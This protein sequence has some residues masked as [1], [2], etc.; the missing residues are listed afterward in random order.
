[1]F[2]SDFTLHFQSGGKTMKRVLS[3][4]LALCLGASLFAAPAYASGEASAEGG[5]VGAAISV[6]DGV[7]SLDEDYCA[8]HGLELSYDSL[9]NEG[10]TGLTLDT[11]DM[12][13]SAVSVTGD[14]SVFTIDQADIHLGVNE[15]TAYVSSS[16]TAGSGAL[17]S[18]GTLF[19]NDSSIVVDGGANGAEGGHYTV[20]ASGTGTLVV[21]NSSMVQTGRGGAEG[22]TDQSN[23]PGSNNG[24]LIAGYARSSMSVGASQTYYYNSYVET[25]GWAAMST[26]SASGSGLDFYSYNSEAYAVSGGYGIYADSSCRD[27]LYATT[28]RAAEHGVILSN[29]GEVHVYAGSAATEEDALKYYPQDG[30]LV[31][32]GSLIEAGRNCFYIHSPGTGAP[33]GKQAIVEVADSTLRTTEELNDQQTLVDYAQKYSQGVADYLEF[34]RGAI[35]VVKSHS[36]QIDLTNTVMDSCT[37]TLIMTTLNSDSTSRYLYTDKEDTPTAVTMT[38]MDVTGDIKDY[39]Y[40]RNLTVTLD[41]TAWSGASLVWDAADWNAYWDYAKGESGVYWYDLDSETYNVAH[42][43]TSLT[44]ENGSVWTVT[45]D[46]ALDS[47]TIGADCAV[48]CVQATVDGQPVMLEAGNAYEGDIRL[49][50]AA[51]SQEATAPVG[52]DTSEEAYHAYLKE[53]VS[54]VPAVSDDQFV[55]FAALIDASGYTSMPADM[56]FSPEWWGYAAMTYE[57]FVAAGGAY[58]IPAFDPGLTAD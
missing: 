14:D 15:E 30:A 22:L 18:S 19:I 46:S 55:E 56:L 41:N 44:L 8:Q 6:T 54:A 29:N 25:E 7:M 31:S 9:T 3:T 21:N 28:L 2:I 34:I 5:S 57:E 11:G 32:D 27:W 1:M 13:V 43:G 45:A 48:V 58:E 42:H 12:L 35:V 33:M 53:Y 51:G 16:E 17:V 20:K 23:E 26:D 49:T 47:L 10:V 50:A 24:L 4:A 40:Q 36:A 38:D 39:D 37:D 52:G